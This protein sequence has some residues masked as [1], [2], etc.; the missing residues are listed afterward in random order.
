M[1]PTEHEFA[2]R[3]VIFNVKFSQSH[4]FKSFYFGDMIDWNMPVNISTLLIDDVCLLLNDNTLKMA[5]YD[6]SFQRLLW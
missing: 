5:F 6:I 1:I 3:D 4:I 2:L